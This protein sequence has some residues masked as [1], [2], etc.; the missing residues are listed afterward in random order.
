[1]HIK[2]H[3]ATFWCYDVMNLQGLKIFV[4]FVR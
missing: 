4:G 3:L 1:M 2:A